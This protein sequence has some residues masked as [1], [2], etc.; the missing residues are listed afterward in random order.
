MAEPIRDDKGRFAKDLSNQARLMKEIE[1]TQSRINALKANFIEGDKEQEKL[2]KSQNAYLNKLLKIN[3]QN[4]AEIKKQTENFEDMD[5]AMVSIGNKLKNNSKLAEITKDKFEATKD[6]SKIITKELAAGGVKNNKSKDQVI[7]ALDAY[8]KSQISIAQANKEKSLGNISESERI[9]L[10]DKANESFQTQLS[11]VD[12]TLISSQDLLDTLGAM[13]SEAESFSKGI[14]KAKINSEQLDAAFSNF[15]GIPAMSELNNLL[16]TNIKDTVAFKAAVFAL[17]AALGKAAM[18]YFGAPMKAQIQQTKEVAQLAIDGEAER[19]KIAMDK[20]FIDRDAAK[21]YSKIQ[22]ESD[23]N[24]IETAHNVAQAMNEAAF[25]GQ[26]AAIQFSAQM[27][28]GAAQF[29]RAAKTALFGNKLGGV[30]YGAAQMALAGISADKVA[31]G[32][33]AASAATGRMPS[34]KVG[35]DMAIMAERT[36]TS[37]DNIAS[38]NE[39]FQRMDGVSESTA[40]NLSE[41]LRNMADQAKIGLGGLMREIADASKDALSYQIKSG[42]ALAKQVAYAQSLGVSFGDIAKAGKSMVMNYKDSIKQEM[43]LSAMLGKNVD[44]SEVRAKFASGDQAGAMEAL[45]AQGLDPA[46]MD[47]FQQDALSQAL[48]GMDL[49][50][51]QKIATKSGA[52]VGGLKEGKAGAGNQDFL[53][54]TQAAESALNS[55]QASISAQTAILDAKLSGKIADSFINS[56]GHK[57]FLKAQADQAAKSSLLNQEMESLYKNSKA[58]NDQLAKTAQNEMVSGI[59]ENLLSG[60]SMVLG[61]VAASF[62][63]K[64]V[65]I[66]GK[67][68]QTMFSKAGGGGGGVTSMATS[69]LGGGGGAPPMPGGGGGGGMMPSMPGGGGAPGGA[70]GGGFTKGLVDSIKGVSTILKSIITELGA[71]LKSGVDVVMQLANKLAS[72]VMTT[73]NTIMSGLSKAS[74][75]MPTILGNLGKAIGSFFSGMGTGLVTFA[76]MMATP[77]ALFGL[78]VGL[79]VMAMMM[80]LAA[81]MRIAAPAIEAMT[82]LILGLVSILGDTFVRALEAAGPIITS[83]FEGIGLVIEKVGNAISGIINSITD[84]ISRLGGLNPAQLLAVAGGIAALAGAVA[85]FGG[86]SAIGG[87][88]SAIGEFFGGDPVDKFLK[89]QNLDPA[90]LQ[91]VATSITNLATGISAFGVL[92]SVA[93]VSA[94]LTTA[95]TNFG[96]S[97]GGGASE[98]INSLASGLRALN[99]QLIIT[100]SIAGSIDVISSAFLNLAYALDRL[101]SV[102]TKALNDVPWIRMTAF[103][104]A[105]GRITLAQSANN[106]FNI[107]QDTAK[108][109]EKMT[110]NT[111]VMVK[112]NNTIAKLIKEGF[113]G[114]ET[115]GQMKLYIDGKDVSTSMKRYN[116]NTQNQD[117]NKK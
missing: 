43:Q 19:A 6:I 31:A 39:M 49:S 2:I 38:I 114:S 74:G 106:S 77:T 30:G 1:Q 96:E 58:Y 28:S 100:T 117:P 13:G 72:G 63:T 59:K 104:G 55:K 79:I 110:A 46:S 56:D 84:S 86:A 89:F 25:A 7:A 9:N 68:L 45:K 44:L 22:E 37:V 47:M 85:I 33:E 73:F 4:T 64:G 92:E 116:S 40:M 41:G 53:S 54:R 108:N 93:G 75:T 5:D 71:V 90:Q 20:G 112:L 78:P 57:N 98:G 113:F 88:M 60:L 21:G 16:K 51:L 32:M 27:Q 115:T 76:Q 36:G 52:Q 61:G 34:A 15:S 65:G 12:R 3:K 91:A 82:P 14:Q 24:R 83:I 103:A 26:K 105:G 11:F 66:L 101:A 48:G 94:A 17:G 62:A 99:E 95:F 70:P 97:V 29:E 50:S 87:F 10:I 69:M 80:G 23:N 109:I 42:P 111:E 35:A 107:A 18:D 81:A 67:G 102:N 8:K